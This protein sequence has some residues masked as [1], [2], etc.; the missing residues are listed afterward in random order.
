MEAHFTPDSKFL[1]L[2]STETKN[3]FRSKKKNSTWYFFLLWVKKLFST[4]IVINIYFGH[5]KI[6]TLMTAG[7]KWYSVKVI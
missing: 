6:F 4:R 2:N 7:Q 3:L 1:R 5:L